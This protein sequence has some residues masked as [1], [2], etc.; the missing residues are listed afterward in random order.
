MPPVPRERT[1]T[2]AVRQ[3]SS[4]RAPRV[5]FVSVTHKKATLTKACWSAFRCGKFNRSTAYGESYIKWFLDTGSIPVIST[6]KTMENDTFSIVFFIHCESNGIS[7][8]LG[9]YHH[10]RCISSTVGCILFRNDDI[11]ARKRDILVFG[12]MI[13]NFWRNWWY[14]TASRWFKTLKEQR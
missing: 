12:R 11:L 13:C 1:T 6:K 10:R 7:S 2:H 8:P 9:V 3:I 14:T 4:A 5:A